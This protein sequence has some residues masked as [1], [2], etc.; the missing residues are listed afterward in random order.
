MKPSRL[1]PLLVLAASPLFTSTLFPQSAPV[2]AGTPIPYGD[3]ADLQYFL[4]KDTNNLVLEFFD[5][6]G[7]KIA[8]IQASFQTAAPSAGLHL[9]ILGNQT[10]PET[11]KLYWDN[12]GNAIFTYDLGAASPS[13]L[14]IYYDDGQ[15]PHEVPSAGTIDQPFA[16]EKHISPAPAPAPSPTTALPVPPG[17][18]APASSSSAT[19]AATFPVGVVS[20]SGVTHTILVHAPIQGKVFKIAPNGDIAGEYTVGVKGEDSW[21]L[22]NGRILASYTSG[23]R[24]I[25]P[26][27]GATTWEYKAGPGVEI[28]SCQ[29]LPGDRVL[30]CECGSKRLFE[31]NRDLTIAHE[32]KLESTQVTHKQFRL[33]RKTDAGTYLVAYG[34]DAVVRELDA[35][36]KTLQTFVAPPTKNPGVNGGFRLPNGNTLVT[37]GYGAE[38]YEFDH[39]AQIVWTLRQSDLPANFN[40]HY[41]GTAQRLPNGNTLVSNFQGEPEVFEVTPDKHVVWQFHNEKTG[42]V[43]ACFLIN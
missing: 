16:E 36:G 6:S 30:I 15:G 35:D 31:I 25:D 18:T 7:V 37:G 27:T 21:L 14:H 41:L 28:H 9:R 29:P 20:A 2:A 8:D 13:S 12:E 40:L 33:A 1:A 34:S 32:I 19:S 24:E 17:A 22:P 4:L 43:S 3:F 23:V 5:G 42:P 10:G 38:V 11:K 26:A 39:D